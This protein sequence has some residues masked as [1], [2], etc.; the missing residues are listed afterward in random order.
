M[1]KKKFS[2][3]ELYNIAESKGRLYAIKLNGK[4]LHVSN[5]KSIIQ[6]ERF[7]EYNKK[8]LL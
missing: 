6:I 1:F 3:N 8:V 7:L 4:F 2:M 5:Q